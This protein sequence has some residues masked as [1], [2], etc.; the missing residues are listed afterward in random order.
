MRTRRKE[1]ERKEEKKEEEKRA[2][3][4]KVVGNHVANPPRLV[5]DELLEGVEDARLALLR[6]QSLGK[7]NSGCHGQDTDGI[8]EKMIKM[9]SLPGPERKRENKKIQTCSSAA[10][11]LNM[12]TPSLRASFFDS[13]LTTP[14]KFEAA[15]LLTIGV[16]SWQSLAKL[17]RKKKKRK[18]HLF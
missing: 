9:R 11:S 4:N 2:H 15:A 3:V 8:L 12:A 18:R 10:R 6:S 14:F 16:S 5:V 1:K 17:L 13:S 7:G